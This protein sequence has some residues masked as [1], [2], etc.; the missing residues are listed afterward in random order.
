MVPEEADGEIAIADDDRHATCVQVDR[1]VLVRVR[2]RDVQQGQRPGVL[3]GDR[4]GA[5]IDEAVGGGA[6]AQGERLALGDVRGERDKEPSR[7][8][9]AWTV[10]G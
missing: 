5:G 10:T 2:A 4:V 6:S 3:L 9:F 1:V 8:I 7:S